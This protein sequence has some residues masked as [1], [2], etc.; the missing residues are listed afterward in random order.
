MGTKIIHTGELAAL[1]LLYEILEASS[2]NEIIETRLL[3][4][5]STSGSREFMDV[6]ELTSLIHQLVQYALFV[7]SQ[8]YDLEGSAQA[9]L[10]SQT[11]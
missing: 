4:N 9:I 5:L 2:P 3:E 6:S 11:P 8:D 10:Q 7:N 1:P